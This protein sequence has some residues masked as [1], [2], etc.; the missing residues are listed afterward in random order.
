LLIP[1]CRKNLPISPAVFTATDEK[2][3]DGFSHK[4]V[5]AGYLGVS[6]ALVDVAQILPEF[7]GAACMF[8]FHSICPITGEGLR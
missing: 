4:A 2:S 5:K 3:E 1:D 6:E 7:F 8:S